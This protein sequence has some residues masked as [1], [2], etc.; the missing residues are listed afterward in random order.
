MHATRI[1]A[2]A[3]DPASDLRALVGGGGGGG[4]GGGSRKK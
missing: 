4:E 3:P 2:V 1:K